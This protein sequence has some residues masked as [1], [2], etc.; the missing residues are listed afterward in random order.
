MNR[1]ERAGSNGVEGSRNGAEP[2]QRLSLR[3]YARWRKCAPSAVSKAISH[4]R[5]RRGPDGL[6][7]VA[8]CDA[9]WERNSA[10]KRGGGPPRAPGNGAAGL[11]SLAVSSA[12]R[13]AW[14]A[15]RERLQY[16]RE[17]GKLVELEAVQKHLFAVGRQI[18]DRLLAVAD[19]VCP[20]IGDP[21]E[22]VR[23]DAALR[24]EIRDALSELVMDFRKGSR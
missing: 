21:N 15:R 8:Q 12:V 16:E 14:A 3:A 6:L 4:G 9:D 2:G 11:P 7:D 1:N 24:V 19:R 22:R 17:S 5:I 20:T 10:R 13:Q 18:R 23:I